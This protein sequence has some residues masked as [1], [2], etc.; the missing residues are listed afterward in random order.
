MSR[1]VLAVALL[2]L[3]GTPVARAASI[4]YTFNITGS[5][6]L[7]GTAFT[8]KAVTITA[9]GKTSDVTISLPGP[10]PTSNIAVES[11]SVSV[12]G[13]GSANFLFTKPEFGID[14]TNSSIRVKDENVVGNPYYFA[15]YSPDFANYTLDH[16]ISSTAVVNTG[17]NQLTLPTSG[18]DFLL[19]S[20]SSVSFTASVVPEPSTLALGL[21]GGMVVAGCAAMSRRQRR[22]GFS[23]SA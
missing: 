19:G 4:A 6:T 23:V 9:I 11:A 7:G 2:A 15:G 18:G 8:D 20:L 1:A 3:L 21:T 5:G 16:A 22:G 17:L 10:P 12:V 13:L 14:V